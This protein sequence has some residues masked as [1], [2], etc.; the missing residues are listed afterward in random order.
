MRQVRK[1]NLYATKFGD[2]RLRI[3]ESV[4]AFWRSRNNVLATPVL[5]ENRIYVASGQEAEHGD[6][7]GRLVC[8]DPTKSG[9][10]SSE[11]AVDADGNILPHRR[12]QA[13]IAEQGERAIPNPDSGLVWEFTSDGNGFEEQLHRTF[14]TVAIQSGRLVVP[15]FAGLVHCFDAKTGKRL[16]FYDC[17][18]AIW[19]TPLIVDGHV[20]V[21]D[22]DG[23]VAIFQL[24]TDTDAE[25]EQG[26]VERQ[27]LAEFDL[28]ETILASPVF[29]NG[30]LYVPTRSTLYAIANPA[31][32]AD[33]RSRSSHDLSTTTDSSKD[34][35]R[36]PNAA[37][38]PTPQDVVARML[39]LAAVQNDDI[40]FDLGSG[41]GRIVITAAETYGCRAVGYE[42]DGKLIEESQAAAVEAG[43]DEL[44]T[45]H[46]ADLF[47]A[48]LKDADVITLFLLPIQNKR[49]VPILQKLQ[50]GTRIV[51]HH[52][53]IPGIVPDK[54]VQCESKDSDEPHRLSL[55][56]I[57]LTE[58]EL[59]E[60]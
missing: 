24:Q 51:T 26:A 48:D 38:T 21:C 33:A 54:V 20:Y 16:W 35:R 12:I 5:Y 2:T 7:P 6:G 34:L 44:V 10:I 19:S 30:T 36:V 28:G 3:W 53:E 15:D 59:G 56:T 23:E 46:R 1:T 41:D 18:S 29:A 25:A 57:P 32:K 9:D 4:T 13:V 17:L 22:E 45:F 27:P 49:L 43:V 8:L 47:A 37:F 11:L 39:E 55:F 42:I 50:P 60:R 40:V 52:F 31:E 58:S 14:S